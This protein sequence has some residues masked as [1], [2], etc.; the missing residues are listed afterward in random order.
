MKQRLG[1]PGRWRGGTL[2]DDGGL[3][4]H[5]YPFGVTADGQGPC[6]E[7]DP[8]YDHDICWCHF[9]EC[10]GIVDEFGFPATG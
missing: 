1:W 9:D 5:L 8:A 7:S 3:P 10:I 2:Y 4:M 6:D